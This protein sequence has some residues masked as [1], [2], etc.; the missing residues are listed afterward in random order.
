VVQEE[1]PIEVKLSPLSNPNTA[2]LTGL[3]TSILLHAGVLLVGVLFFLPQV[4]DAVKSL[5]VSEQN[6]I[7]TAE[8]ATDTPGGIPNPGMNDD[9]SRASA[10]SVDSTVTQSDDWAE[11]KSDNLNQALSGS[12]AGDATPTVISSY[13]GPTSGATG[14]SSGSTGGGKL[15]KFGP[16]GGGQ[17][18]GPKGA[19]FGNGGNAVKIVFVCDATGS[20]G[21]RWQVLVRELQRT[22]GSLKPVQSFNILLFRDGSFV[23]MDKSALVPGTPDNKKKADAF[24]A[25]NGPKGATFPFEAI[26]TSMKLK[27]DLVYILVDPAIFDTMQSNNPVQEFTE[28]IRK[29]RGSQN[30]KINFIMFFARSADKTTKEAEA[31]KKTLDGLAKEFGGKLTPVSMEDLFSNR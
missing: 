5:I 9:S 30:I 21:N 18:M 10:Q 19:V 31:V 6:I 20:M 8:L 13:G 2:A 24:L 23:A 1:H 27:P 22:I 26:E 3:A 11:A 12:A 4:S 29:A 25:A 15:A 7:P 28:S 17:G 14:M 16:P